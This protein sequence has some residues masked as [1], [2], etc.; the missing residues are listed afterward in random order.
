VEGYHVELDKSSLTLNKKI[1]NAQIAQ[2]N[3]IAVVGAQ[4]K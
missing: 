3:Y 2:F 4:E 1:R